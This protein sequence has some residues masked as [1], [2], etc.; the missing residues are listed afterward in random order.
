MSV[1]IA[2]SLGLVKRSLV[3]T[4]IHDEFT[5]GFVIGILLVLSLLALWKVMKYYDQP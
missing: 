2:Q 4:L 5:R 3:P 1:I